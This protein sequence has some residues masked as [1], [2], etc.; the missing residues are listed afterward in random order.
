MRNV[1]ADRLQ[2]ELKNP[3]SFANFENALIDW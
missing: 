3:R 2:I 1:Q